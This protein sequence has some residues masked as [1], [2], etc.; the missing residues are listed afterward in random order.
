M[1]NCPCATM[2][3]PVSDGTCT[4]PCERVGFGGSRKGISGFAACN[5]PWLARVASSLLYRMG[6]RLASDQDKDLVQ[7]VLL[8]VLERTTDYDPSRGSGSCRARAWLAGILLNV[9]KQDLRAK[10]RVKLVEDPEQVVLQAHGPE[11]EWSVLLS[12]V[13]D[14]LTPAERELLLTYY[15]E[16]H[17]SRE[18]STT[19]GVREVTVRQRVL[20]LRTRI[21]ERER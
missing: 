3:Q 14:Q 15:V 13:C 11:G 19:L 18:I 9:V 20:R 5:L 21:M 4:K 7:K 12:E 17:S 10:R 16:G 2:A 8:V 6:G 1:C